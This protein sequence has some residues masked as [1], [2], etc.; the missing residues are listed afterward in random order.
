MDSEESGGS[1]FGTQGQKGWEQHA[2]LEGVTA[3]DIKQFRTSIMARRF[4]GL[5]HMSDE[6]VAALVVA[7]RAATGRRLD[8][9]MKTYP[10]TQYVNG[11]KKTREDPIWMP[12]SATE[13]KDSIVMPPE[14][15]FV[16]MYSPYNAAHEDF[17]EKKAE[18]TAKILAGVGFVP[19]NWSE[20]R[21]TTEVDYFLYSATANVKM[22][23][24]TATRER[25]STNMSNYNQ[26][27][28]N[29]R[30]QRLV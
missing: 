22:A 16:G 17:L 3:A 18:D 26:V 6:D 25:M 15:A 10:K 2:G 1:L 4:P 14:Q 9:P 12:N 20:A 27:G 11:E 30:G 5:K 19:S 23:E 7:D 24:K 13:A 28:S 8:P 29:R 21:N